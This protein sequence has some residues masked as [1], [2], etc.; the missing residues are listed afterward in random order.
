MPPEPYEYQGQA[1]I[2]AFLSDRTLRRGAPRLVATRANAQPAFGV[3]F[4]DPDTGVARPYAMIV[5]TLQGDRISAI[6]WFGAS[7]V[8][9]RFGLPHVLS[10]S[11]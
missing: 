6:T 10:G 5:L 8:V 9:A 2:G 7:S 4:P 11:T 3:Y 1:A